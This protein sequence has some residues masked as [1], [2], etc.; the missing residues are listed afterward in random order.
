[1]IKDIK[2]GDVIEVIGACEVHPNNIPVT[3]LYVYP[4]NIKK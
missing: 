4:V 1:M 3:Q 2:V